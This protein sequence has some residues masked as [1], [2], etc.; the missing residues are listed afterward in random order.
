MRT[1]TGIRRKTRTQSRDRIGSKL[2]HQE[3]GKVAVA[4]ESTDVASNVSAALDR[5]GVNSTKR[6]SSRVERALSSGKQRSRYLRKV[7]RQVATRKAE[8]LCGIGLSGQAGAQ[9]VCSRSS[10]RSRLCGV[11][12]CKSAS[13]PGC[14]HHQNSELVG[15][16]VPALEGADQAGYKIFFFTLTLRHDQST[17]AVGLKK[18]FSKCWNAT[19]T[20]LKRHLGKG[21]FEYFWK[22]D[23]NWSPI[24]GHHLH[25]HG[26]LVIKNHLDLEE[27]VGLQDT[28]FESWD[29]QAVRNGFGRCSREAFYCEVVS[30]GSGFEA[31]ARYVNKLVKTAFEVASSD[32]KRGHGSLS[33]F[34]LLEEMF[35]APDGSEWGQR[36]EDAYLEYRAATF[37]RRTYGNS[38][39]F[40]GLKELRL[41]E[42]YAPEIENPIPDA[43]EVELSELLHDFNNENELEFPDWKVWTIV[44]PLWKEMVRHGDTEDVQTILEEGTPGKF[45]DTREQMAFLELEKL[46]EHARSLVFGAKK[47]PKQF[48]GGVGIDLPLPNP[49]DQFEVRKF[50]NVYREKWLVERVAAK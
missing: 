18:G 47:P 43:V 31:A 4:S 17:T 3:H 35:R 40:F 28:L 46:L 42:H 14:S 20:A 25:L 12:F 32:Y 37:R 11:Y 26:L 27:L 24:S 33:Q 15:K 21:S 23:Y 9:V 1:N 48:V 16:V 29:K 5:S 30:A 6:L 19:N 38:K 2:R 7:F 50:W 36:L 34:Q 10:V 49:V 39:G 45:R 13:C 44:S 41:E 22:Q 8:M